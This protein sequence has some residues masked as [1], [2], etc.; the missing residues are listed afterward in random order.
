MAERSILGR[1]KL[2]KK[3]LMDLPTGAYLVS[4]CFKPVGPNRLAPAFTENVASPAEREAQWRR[5]KAAGIDQR[6]CF[7]YRNVED[8]ERSIRKDT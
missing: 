8:Y 4:N 1:P 3:V 5:I 7:V 6:L 2:S